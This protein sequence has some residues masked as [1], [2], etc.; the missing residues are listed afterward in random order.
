[1]YGYI[2]KTTNLINGKI[3]IGQKKS[4]IFLGEKYLGSGIELVS[5]IKKYGKENF[6]VELIEEL[7][8]KKKLDEREIYWIDKYN[9]RNKQ[10]GY[11]IAEGGEGGDTLSQLSEE[12]LLAC[13]Q[14]MSKSHKGRIVSEKT[15]KK[16]SEINKGKYYL[17]EEAKERVRQ[18]LIGRVQT[19]E[20]KEKR[21]IS[22]K[23]FLEN[24]PNYMK[25]V[26]GVKISKTKK[27]NVIIS[28]EQKKQI[29][30]TLKNY[31]KTHKPYIVGKHH[32]KET[33]EIIS[34]CHKGRVF[35][36]NRLQEK[37]IKKEDLDNYLKLGW[38][39]GRINGKTFKKIICLETNIIYTTEEL[40]KILNVKI[41]S[42]RYHLRNK[43]PIKNLHFEYIDN[44][45]K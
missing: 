43:T 37:Q 45:N 44:K 15:R 6:K 8:T 1:M 25:E 28:N 24:N 12:K 40:A 16:L 7:P 11:N 30:N 34:S 33:K 2:Y 10:I 9:S 21:K 39:K 31:F 27:G 3:Y 17:T 18:K 14:K 42:V 5:A 23:K 20:E 13:K 38:T 41:E 22:R 29:S 19:E 36:N 32:T 35:I 26:V 4:T